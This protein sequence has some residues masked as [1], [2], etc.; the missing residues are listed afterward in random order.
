MSRLVGYGLVGGGGG[1]GGKDRR[2]DSLLTI[3]VL[4]SRIIREFHD[5]WTNEWDPRFMTHD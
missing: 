4:T 5:H 1:G 3:E 2:I